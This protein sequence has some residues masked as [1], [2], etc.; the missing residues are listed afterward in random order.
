LK[1]KREATNTTSLKLRLDQIHLIREMKKENEW[2]RILL[3]EK[4]SKTKLIYCYRD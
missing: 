4:M 3:R 1:D 2:I